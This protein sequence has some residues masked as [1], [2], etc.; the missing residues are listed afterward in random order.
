ML[1]KIIKIT[2]NGA[3]LQITDHETLAS[4]LINIHI[5]FEDEKKKILGE[6]VDIDKDT[7]RV[8]FL[9]EFEQDRFVGGIIR[10]PSLT[11][12]TRVIT[13]DELELVVGKDSNQ[14]MDIG[15]SPLYNGYPIRVDI[16]DLFSNHL[17]I[18]GN[19]GSGK[20]WGTARLI[21]NLFQS[22]KFVAFKANI[23]IFD[24]YGEY[25][26]AFKNLNQINPNFNFKVYSTLKEEADHELIRIPLWLLDVDDIA[27]LLG[28]TNTAQIP[29][30]EETLKLASIFSQ[31][32]EEAHIY[33]NHLIAKA[34][35]SVMYTN[36][37]AAKIRNQIF[38]ILTNCNTP[39]LN[40]DVDVQGLGF[41]RKFRACFDIDKEGK[42]AESV[43]ITNYISSFIQPNQNEYEPDHPQQYGLKDL[44]NALDFALISEGFLNN[45]RA[46][47]DSI[48]LKV[49]LHSILNS[50]LGKYFEY[51][52]YTTVEDYITSLLLMP[53]GKRAQIVNFNI[54]D[55][56]DRFA[57]VIT[58]IYSK[59]LFNFAKGLKNKGSIPFHLLL[60]EA[61]RYVQNDNDRNLIGYNI[62]D[63]I[64]KEGRKYGIILDLIS[65]RPTELSETTLS[66]CSNF[67]IFKITHPTDLEYIRTMVPNINAEIIEKQKNLQP[68]ICVAFGR[69]FKIPMIM[70]MDKP[71]PTPTSSNCDIFDK[72]MIVNPTPQ[73]APVQPTAPSMEAKPAPVQPTA[74]S[75]EPK[76]APVQPTIPVTQP[77]HST[78]EPVI[79]VEPMPQPSIV[80]P[81][82]PTIQM[83]SPIQ[84][85][86]PTIEVVPP[87]TNQPVTNLSLI[88][89]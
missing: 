41:S 89:I 84:T 32:D 54:Q 59:M 44:E 85:P 17:A 76:P 79:P 31:N 53:N 4:D 78:P 28:A 27:L 24:A 23:F 9:G 30:I 55:V 82:Q 61:H 34:L 71:D 33:K 52:S 10:K 16:N 5:V 65:Q 40:L 73:P 37:I 11:S 69:S 87:V 12:N 74:P 83:E 50:N 14:S 56:D 22:K 25:H 80:T 1:G 7:I 63:R 57:K 3:I 62:F 86:Q 88:H 60:E 42:F 35:I 48:F 45:D 81:T 49:R 26:N 36:Q 77:S 13:D 29:I 39:E 38:A 21:Q 46:Y 2:E 75:V 8:N 43:L 51:D 67:L 72:W 6:V 47:S 64:A 68:G 19:T 70:R 15:F 58:K 66:Q 18:F 20:S